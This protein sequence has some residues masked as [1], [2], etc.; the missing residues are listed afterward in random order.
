MG[1]SSNRVL[2]CQFRLKYIRK[3]KW[4]C[5]DFDVNTKIIMINNENND[6]NE[7]NENENDEKSMD[8]V[9]ILQAH[10]PSPTTSQS[11]LESNPSIFVLIFTIKY[12]YRSHQRYDI[13][14]SMSVSAYNVGENDRYMIIYIWSEALKKVD[15][16]EEGNILGERETGL[17]AF[18]SGCMREVRGSNKEFSNL[19]KIEQNKDT[20][21]FSACQHACSVFL[22]LLCIMR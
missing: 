14:Q 10:S 21:K 18:L 16:A 17:E 9:T 13:L 11:N 7:N 20:T 15:R 4:Y 3:R 12:A 19:A 6:D 8:R 1:Y 22:L 5:I 2:I